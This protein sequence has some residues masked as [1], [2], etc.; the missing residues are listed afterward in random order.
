MLDAASDL[1]HPD[2]L[3]TQMLLMFWEEGV[4][5]V[6]TISRI[7]GLFGVE[8]QR[9]NAW[10]AAASL[11]LLTCVCPES[12]KGVWWIVLLRNAVRGPRLE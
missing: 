3:A 9:Y 2:Q 7:Q 12:A 5:N 8:S 6:N 11:L 4:S 1:K 10:A